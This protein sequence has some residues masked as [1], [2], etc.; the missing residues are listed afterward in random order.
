MGT[1][2]TGTRGTRAVTAV[3]YLL[4]LVLG[5]LEGGIGSFQYGQAPSPLIAVVLALVVLVTCAGC[6]WGMGSVT[7]ALLPAVGWI[8]ASFVLASARANGSVIITATA[9]G[10]WY[11]YGGAVACIAGVLGYIV[12]R[13]MRSVPRSAAPGPRPAPPR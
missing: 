1:L 2:V 9:A 12:F 4:L 7:A 11:L 3:G 5:L 10:E 6:G 13:A 8:V